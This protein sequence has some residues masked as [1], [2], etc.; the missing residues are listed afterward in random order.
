MNDDWDIGYRR[1][2]RQHVTKM[3][4]VLVGL[5]LLGA[6]VIVGLLLV[7]TKGHAAEQRTTFTDSN[8]RVTGWANSDSKGNTTYSNALGQN[9]GRSTTDANGTTTF[10]DNMGRQTGTVRK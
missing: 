10:R 6:T 1:A 5:T 2:A 8:G 9:T 7:S 4:S 3:L